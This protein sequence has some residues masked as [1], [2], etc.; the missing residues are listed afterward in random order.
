MEGV[1]WNLIVNIENSERGINLG[2]CLSV[3]P[4]GRESCSINFHFFQFVPPH[5][6]TVASLLRRRK[7][8]FK[9]KPE[10]T[11]GHRL[12]SWQVSRLLNLWVALSLLPCSRREE[13]V[14]MGFGSAAC[15]VPN[16][17]TFHSKDEQKDS[18]CKVSPN[19]FPESSLAFIGTIYQYFLHMVDQRVAIQGVRPPP[20]H[21]EDPEDWQVHWLQPVRPRPLCH[22]D[23]GKEQVDQRHQGQR[24][25]QSLRPKTLH[26]EKV[27][28][29]V[30]RLQ[31]VRPET[32]RLEDQGQ[33]EG[34]RVQ[35]Q[36]VYYRLFLFS[37]SCLLSISPYL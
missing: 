12:A 1:C 24:R 4:T 28:K 11:P 5:V 20:L 17:C 27:T 33:G 26:H 32:L 6:I 22:D 7:A 29:S 36:S 8:K 23:Q 21:P 25:V 9:R 19:T 2:S 13:S 31:S 14:K 37:Q 30:L 35:V 10:T 3:D 15:A 16:T 34:G 18:D